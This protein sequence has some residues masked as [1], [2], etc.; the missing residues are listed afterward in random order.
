MLPFVSTM[1]S[2]VFV[3]CLA[4]LLA[5]KT[6]SLSLRVMQGNASPS[7]KPSDEHWE[8]KLFIWAHMD[9]LAAGWGPSQC[10]ELGGSGSQPQW[11]RESF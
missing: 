4:V 6:V 11:R 10:R 3:S 8:K 1:A 5:T 2:H 9:P 7:E